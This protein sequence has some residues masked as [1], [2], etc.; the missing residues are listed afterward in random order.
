MPGLPTH[1]PTQT[2]SFQT[3]KS[4]EVSSAT[5]FTAAEHMTFLQTKVSQFA[6]VK[7]DKD[8][9]LSNLI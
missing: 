4:F 8:Y 6:F 1:K 7:N 9:L 3:G 5:A 2:K